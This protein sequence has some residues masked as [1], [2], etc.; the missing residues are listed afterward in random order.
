MGLT[1]SQRGV[2]ER[3][4]SC[5]RLADVLPADGRVRK[6]YTTMAYVLREAGLLE[7]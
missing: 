3:I 4:L 7:I 1:R 5:A 6:A 2:A